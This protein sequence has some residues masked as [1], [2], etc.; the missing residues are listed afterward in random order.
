MVELLGLVLFTVVTVV[1]LPM[2]LNHMKVA[3]IEDH[4]HK[5]VMFLFIFYT[6][7]CLWWAGI[8][9]PQITET[10]I[11]QQKKWNLVWSYAVV[12]VLGALIFCGYWWF[13]GKMCNP[14]FLSKDTGKS[15]QSGTLPPPPHRQTPQDVTEPELPSLEKLFKREFAMFLRASNERNFSTEDAKG[16]RTTKIIEQIY[17]DFQ[18]KSKFL[19]FYVPPSL[20]AYDMCVFLSDGYK[21]IIKEVNS[22]TEVKSGHVAELSQTSSKDLVFTGRI[23]ISRRFI[24]TPTTC[25]S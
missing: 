14:Q 15:K 19:G 13:A 21:T 2:V 25:R 5:W 18:G 11:K 10:I 8:N 1:V 17:F 7:C 16:K 22:K 24:F 3:W 23:Y 4:L 12:G 6:C 20:D 9:Y